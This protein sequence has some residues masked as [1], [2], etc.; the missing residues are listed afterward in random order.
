MSAN[1][2]APAASK[3]VTVPRPAPPKASDAKTEALTPYQNF[4]GTLERMKPQFMAALPSHIKPERL[5]RII[6]TTVNKTPELLECT[7]ASLLGGLMQCAQLG[8]EPDGVLGQAY[9]IPFRNK[10]IKEVQLIPGYKGLI[11]LAYQSG[12]VGHITARVV[13]EKDKFNYWYG[14]DEGIEHTPWRGSDAGP[15]VAAYAWASIKGIESKQFVVLER[16]EVDAIRAR[17]KSGDKG[18][19]VT[20]YEEM[21]K[22]SALRRL[23]KMLPAS[24]EKDNLARAVALDEHAASG[25]SQQLDYR[26]MI[27]V[28]VEPVQVPNKS[29]APDPGPAGDGPE[30]AQAAG[31]AGAKPASMEDIAA[32]ARAA[33]ESATTAAEAG[34]A[35]AKSTG[36]G[37]KP[38]DKF[39][40]PRLAA[41]QK[42]RAA[43]RKTFEWEGKIEKVPPLDPPPDLDELHDGMIGQG[44]AEPTQPPTEPGSEG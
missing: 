13:R 41:I 43:G 1:P 44:G 29:F 16:W 31:D 7:P 19:W 34:A 17:S 28:N 35:A 25:L 9:L 8:L 26:D 21:A 2:P 6:L 3:T 39:V 36:G 4:K 5:I 11:K 18:P 32:K 38:L 30:T 10:G 12:E 42:A 40:G 14:L 22:K 33:R 37:D 24:V 27:D 15:L 20:D 23:C